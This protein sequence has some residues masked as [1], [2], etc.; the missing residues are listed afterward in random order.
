V[1]RPSP[2]LRDGLTIGRRVAVLRTEAGI[3]G[4]E[5]AARAGISASQLSRIERGRHDPSWSTIVRLFAALGKEVV[6]AGAP[7]DQAA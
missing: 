6:I 7:N 1:S 4:Q 3:S 2:L 5:L